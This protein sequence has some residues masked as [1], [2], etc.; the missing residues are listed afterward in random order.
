MTM[1][2]R[3]SVVAAPLCLEQISFENVCF[4]VCNAH[5]WECACGVELGVRCD[6]EFEVGRGKGKTEDYVVLSMGERECGCDRGVA[7]YVVLFDALEGEYLAI[8]P[9]WL[10]V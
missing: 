6:W 9:W 10:Y 5:D 7:G 8:G 3:A 1:P 2:R 4:T